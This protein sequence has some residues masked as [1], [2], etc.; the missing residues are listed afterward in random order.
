M[1][2]YKGYIDNHDSGSKRVLNAIEGTLTSMGRHCWYPDETLVPLALLDPDLPDVEQEIAKTLFSKQFPDQ[3]QHSEDS[4][5]FKDLHFKQET[6]SGLA[7]LFGENSW[8]IF[9]LLN[10]TKMEDKLWLNTPASVL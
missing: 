10:L 8:F 2:Q 9:S 3:F 7:T 6:P 5:L 4:N 1:V